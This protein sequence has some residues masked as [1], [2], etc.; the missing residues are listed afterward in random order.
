MVA[1]PSARRGPRLLLAVSLL[2]LVLLA[3][4]GWWVWAAMLR[5]PSFHGLELQSARPAADFSLTSA[6]GQTVR[7]SDFEG[8]VVV[9]Y[10]GYTLCPDVCPMTLAKLAQVRTTIG[11][12]AADLQVMM[13]TV[14]PERDTAEQ[15]A[16]YVSR[17][18]PSFVGLT[19]SP[20]E[21]MTA[22]T[23][24]GV[25]F[26]KQPGSAATGYLVDHTATALVIDRQG[27]LRLVLSP[28][29]DSAQLTSDLRTLLAR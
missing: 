20:A 13:I 24:L 2:A 28:D 23:P 21:I 3:P 18:D 9:L 27:R 26:R 15:L 10:F 8:K 11:A 6:T 25:Y 19:G 7:L 29:L 1:T 22:A 4:L 17:F 12:P 14:D 16:H 5:P